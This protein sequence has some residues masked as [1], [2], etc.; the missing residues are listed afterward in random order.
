MTENQLDYNKRE[1]SISSPG[2]NKWQSVIPVSLTPV[3]TGKGK[4]WEDQWIKVIILN[5]DKIKAEVG[6]RKVKRQNWMKTGKRLFAEW[7]RIRRE[8]EMCCKRKKVASERDEECGGR[9]IK[10]DWEVRKERACGKRRKA[11][12][13]TEHDV[14]REQRTERERQE[15]TRYRRR[16]NSKLEHKIKHESKAM[17]RQT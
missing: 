6:K 15:T 2:E 12:R 14:K 7:E 5:V 13:K 11:W 1:Y 4:R 8:T 16:Q 17:K 9:G 3:V 10:I